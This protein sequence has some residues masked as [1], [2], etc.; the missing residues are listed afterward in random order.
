M[1]LFIY[2]LLGVD[3]GRDRDSQSVSVQNW[4]MRRPF[5]V[6]VMNNRSVESRVVGSERIVNFAISFRG[7]VL[8]QQNF[9]QLQQQKKKPSCKTVETFPV[10]IFFNCYTPDRLRGRI[11]G[12][13]VWSV[14]HKR[15]WKL[16]RFGGKSADC[17]TA[18]LA[19]SVN[20]RRECSLCKRPKHR[21]RAMASNTGSSYHWDLRPQVW[22]IRY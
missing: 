5:T 20:Y 13:P 15:V 17:S 22:P 10:T 3:C 4:N 12:R 11:W 21:N 19:F 9:S 2:R 1:F 16:R 8:W 7:I 14:E 18:C 6:R